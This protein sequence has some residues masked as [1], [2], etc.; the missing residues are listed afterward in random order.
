MLRD[1]TFLVFFIFP[2]LILY[3]MWNPDFTELKRDNREKVILF[4]CFK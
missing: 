4:V 3:H 1:S 2:E